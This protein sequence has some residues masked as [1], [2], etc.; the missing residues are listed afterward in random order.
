MTYG[1][2]ERLERGLKT[3]SEITVCHDRVVEGNEPLIHALNEVSVQWMDKLFVSL[4]FLEPY[5]S[6][7]ILNL[8]WKKQFDFQRG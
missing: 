5:I 2:R 8:V 7:F 1:R 4:I 3:T 6:I